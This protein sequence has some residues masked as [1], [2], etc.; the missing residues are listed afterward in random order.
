[1]F[2]SVPET[3]LPS[4][5]LAISY[6][7]FR[8][9]LY[10]IS[11]RMTSMDECDDIPQLGLGASPMCPCDTLHVLADIAFHTVLPVFPIS[12]QTL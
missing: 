6:S 5:L 2:F 1:M 10:T 4:V 7:P 8:L 3:L 11:S 9:I 12:L